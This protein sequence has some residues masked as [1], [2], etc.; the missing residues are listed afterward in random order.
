MPHTHLPHDKGP[1][2]RT[3]HPRTLSGLCEIPGDPEPPNIVAMVSYPAFSA[4]IPKEPV[5]CMPC[6]TRSMG[7]LRWREAGRRGPSN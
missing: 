3:G 7:H 6:L 4:E 1:D 2:P 5:T